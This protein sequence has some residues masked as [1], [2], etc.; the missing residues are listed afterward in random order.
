[1]NNTKFNFKEIMKLDH[2]LES[3]LGAISYSNKVRN[4]WRGK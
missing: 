2:F 4:F 3:N 1:M